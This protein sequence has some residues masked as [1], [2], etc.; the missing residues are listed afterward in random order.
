MEKAEDP[1]IWTAH[2]YISAPSAAGSST[3]I[4]MLVTM[5]DGTESLTSS[6]K[7]KSKVLAKIFFPEKQPVAQ[8]DSQSMQEQ[9]EQVC[10]LDPITRDQIRRHLAKLKP[11][12]A[13]G[14]DGIPN[15]VLIKCADLIT[16]RLYDIAPSLAPE[17]TS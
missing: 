12:K 15:I 14:P 6:N 16:N 7:D 4:P 5:N 3:W 10:E 13:P 11:Y 17:V 2:R 9:K 1:D 8:P